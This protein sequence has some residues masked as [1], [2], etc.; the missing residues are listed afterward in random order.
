VL[1]VLGTVH[2]V[3]DRMNSNERVFIRSPSI[4]TYVCSV[5]L[6]RQLM[7]GSSFAVVITGGFGAQPVSQV[8][9]WRACWFY[10]QPLI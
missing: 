2:Q 1:D 3:S 6:E 8:L 5:T 4:G 7:T 10:Y 9:V